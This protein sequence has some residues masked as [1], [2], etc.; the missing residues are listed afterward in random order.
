MICMKRLLVGVTIGVAMLTPP[1]F[2]QE[3]AH[4][5]V[6]KSYLI[7]TTQEA[8]FARD[9]AITP[10]WNL[11][12]AANAGGTITM[13]YMDMTTTQNAWLKGGGTFSG[14]DDAEL[15][16]RSAYGV[17]GLYLYL[18]V[19][20]D[21]WQPPA[22]FETDALDFL[23]DKMSSADIR[24]CNPFDCYIQPSW[25]WSLT[26]Y[27][28]QYQISI[29]GGSVPS[30]CRV[31]YFDGAAM[32]WG[33]EPIANLATTYG[34]MNVDI[35]SVSANV[36]VMELYIPWTWVGCSGGVGSMPAEG[37]NIA[38]AMGYNDLDA[39]QATTVGTMLR[40]K[41]KDPFNSCQDLTPPH[42]YCDAWGDVQITGAT[43]VKPTADHRAVSTSGKVGA[44]S[45]YTLKGERVVGQTSMLKAGT[46]LIKREVVNGN[47]KSQ[48]VRAH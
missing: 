32:Y 48:L 31:N 14:P 21:N 46:M 40:W 6:C 43:A 34:G 42:D 38:M 30:N 17:S 33:N 10:F 47:V 15:I 41:E 26:F 5:Q 4:D 27:S 29:G 23:L 7:S 20:D 39:G 22:G 1:L 28:I 16:V 35:V 45:Y 13:D 44:T 11:W 19:H 18:E 9:G 12:D 3:D 2:A 24:A 25:S 36:R 8:A 37:T